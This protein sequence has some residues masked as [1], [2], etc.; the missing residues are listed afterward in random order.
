MT[1]VV[2]ERGKLD[3]TFVLVGKLENVTEQARYVKYAERVVEASVESAGVYHVRH[4][5]LADAAEPLKHR[6]FDNIGF[7]ARQ[8]NK[9]VNGISEPSLFAHGSKRFM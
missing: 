2:D 1:E 3:Q 7:I 8:T 5:E 9:A 6:G 4:S